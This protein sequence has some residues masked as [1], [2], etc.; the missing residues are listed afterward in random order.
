[1]NKSHQLDPFSHTQHRTE[2]RLNNKNS[3]I[4][5]QLR[6]AD[7]SSTTTPA[8]ADYLYNGGL[9]NLISSISLYSGGQQLDTIRNFS[10]FNGFKNLIT[11][12]NK[13]YGLKPYLIG[14]V[15]GIDTHNPQIEIDNFS[16]INI[17]KMNVPLPLLEEINI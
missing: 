14:S 7:I 9:A 15:I 8:D 10:K 12:Q 17:G 4:F 16:N 6:L 3:L 13:A 5:S 1:M 11:S 2:F